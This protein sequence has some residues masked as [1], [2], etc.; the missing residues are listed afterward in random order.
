M[1][2]TG[3]DAPPAVQEQPQVS[4]TYQNHTPLLMRF[5]LIFASSCVLFYSL[6]ERLLKT[7]DESIYAEIAKEMLY[8]HTWLTPHW[9]FQ[10]WFE[11]PPLFMWITALFYRCFGVSEFSSR[12]LGALCGV[13]TIWLTF[14]IGR[15]LMDEWGGFAAALMLLTNGYFLLASRFEAINVPL[16]LCFTVAAYGYLR[17]L[18]GDPRWWYAVGAAIG[19][20]IMLKGAG[21][22]PIPLA[23][24]LALLMDRRLGSLRSHHARNSVLLA[25]AIALPWHLAMLAVHG[26]VFLDEYLGYH[27]LA[28]MKGIEVA[29]QP[30]Y[31]YLGCYWVT[32]APFAVAAL[33]GLI[34]HFRYREHSSIVVSA[35]LVVTVSFSLVGT[36]LAAYV[37]PAYPFISLLAILALRRLAKTATHAIICTALIFP[38]YLFAQRHFLALNY[39]PTAVTYD[40]SMNFGNDPLLRLLN[41]MR[42]GEHEHAPSPLIICLDGFPL[43]KQQSVFYSSRPISQA[44]L[45]VRPSEAETPQQARYRAIKPLSEIVSPTPELIVIRTD[46]YPELISSG[47]YRFAAV[48][49]NGPLLLGQISRAAR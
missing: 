26:R 10:P 33:V 19:T 38:I 12:M 8:G 18:R 45:S 13:A 2:T 9:N 29:S 4:A 24:F 27:V 3:L 14:E 31:F 44:F 41:Q 21:G 40:G 1:P 37:V 5:F 28:R 25:V 7:W 46:M 20:A 17:A 32:F 15:L 48:T 47:E 42:P 39:S 34:F 22:V 16:A 11:K 6:G 49:Q 35:A 36:K 43:D 23:L 30:A